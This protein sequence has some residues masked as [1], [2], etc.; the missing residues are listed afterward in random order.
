LRASCG[1][2]LKLRLNGGYFRH[3]V[4]PFPISQIHV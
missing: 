4:H 3:D 2:S 1:G